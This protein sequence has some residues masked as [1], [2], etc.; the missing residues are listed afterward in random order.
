MIIIYKIFKNT[1]YSLSKII[2]LFTLSALITRRSVRILCYHGI[3]MEDE[4]EWFPAF[5]LSHDKLKRRLDYLKKNNYPI[6]TLDEAI[7]KVADNSQLDCSIVITADDG[8]YN[9]YS[10][11]AKELNQREMPAIFYISTYYVVEQT[12][13]FR[14]VVG[15]LFF[16]SKEKSI[17]LKNFNIGLD[18]VQLSNKLQVEITVELII[19]HYEAHVTEEGRLKVLYEL[20]ELLKVDMKKIDDVRMFHLM[21]IDQM[22]ELDQ[23]NIKMGL[24]THNHFDLVTPQI[25]DSEIVANQEVFE[26]DLGRKSHHFCYPRGIWSPNLWPVLEKHQLKSAT[27]SESGVYNSRSSKFE[28][29]RILDSEN[30]SDI[31]FEAEITGFAFLLRKFFKLPFFPD[32][33][34]KY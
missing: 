34:A 2:G 20:G 5:F 31:E 33:G 9:N 10:I 15:Y 26:K 18:D 32:K 21:T 22:K 6:I 17:N 12:P 30:V 27:T 19:E 8:F 28:I 25:A 4:H 23:G 11:L 3:S 14:Y 1:M 16:K 7:A 24:H 13:Y 29:K